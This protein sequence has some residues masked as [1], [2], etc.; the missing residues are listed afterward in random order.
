MSPEQL[1]SPTLCTW[2][3]ESVSTCTC[4]SRWLLVSGCNICHS[5]LLL[6]LHLHHQTWRLQVPVWWLMER[7]H[8]ENTDLCSGPERRHVTEHDLL[9]KIFFSGLMCF[10]F[11]VWHSQI[12]WTASSNTT[13]NMIQTFCPNLLCSLWFYLFYL[14]IYN[15][16]K[17]QRHRWEKWVI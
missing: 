3:R 12:S 15:F 2:G 9:Q 8:E 7:R 1:P 6:W 4:S 5:A 17:L 10:W 11:H 16:V 13:C 14:S